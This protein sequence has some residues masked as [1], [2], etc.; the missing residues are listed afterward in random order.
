MRPV[1]CSGR[2]TGFE[3]TGRVVCR[4][5]RAECEALPGRDYCTACGGACGGCVTDLCSP[6]QPCAPGSV[7]GREFLGSGTQFRCRS[8]TVVEPTTGRVPCTPRN[9]ICWVPG[10]LKYDVTDTLICASR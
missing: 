9:D 7:C 4:S 6:S 10:E 2:E 1:A 3:V 8:L 5:G